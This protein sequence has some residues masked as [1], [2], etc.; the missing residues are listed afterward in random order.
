MRVSRPGFYCWKNRPE[1]PDTTALKKVMVK[2]IHEESKGTYG[3][4]R[5][6]QVMKRR[7][8]N[9]SRMTIYKFMKELGISGI[10]KRRRNRS[11]SSRVQD[12]K[13]LLQRDFETTKPNK[14]WCVDISYI[15]TKQ[16]WLYLAVVIDLFS[17]RIVGYDF[18]PHQRT[19]LPLKA[20]RKAIES[21]KPKKG[22]IHHSDRGSQYCSEEYLRTLEEQEFRSSLNVAGTCLDNAVVES[23]FSSLKQ[24]CVYRDRFTTRTEA[25]EKIS[26]Y[27]DA[28]YNSKRIHSS[29]NGVSPMEFEH[30]YR[31]KKIHF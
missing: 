26:E 11:K 25:M 31:C 10:P 24:E 6:K 19:S 30:L 1:K 27:I 18:A 29:N 23:F 14:V 22:L 8:I 16:G 7:G 2:S 13:N 9:I 5:I 15:S 17:R 20:L 12:G 4:P 28:F 3:Y 21:R